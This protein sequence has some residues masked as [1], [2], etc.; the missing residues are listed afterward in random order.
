MTYYVLHFLRWLRYQVDR[1]PI[2]TGAARGRVPAA[3]I[4]TSNPRR[5]S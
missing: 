1:K 2:E 3:P 4:P 5:S